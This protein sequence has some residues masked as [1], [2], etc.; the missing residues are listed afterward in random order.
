MRADLMAA[1]I[2]VLLASSAWAGV[3][4]EQPPITDT[5][6]GNY[7]R[8]LAQHL[9]TLECLTSDPNGSVLGHRGELK[10]ATFGS[11]DRICM[12]TSSGPNKGTSWTCV[13]TGDTCPGGSDTFVQ[14]NDGGSCGGDEGFTF[15]ESTNLVNINEATDGDSVLLLLQ[16]DQL[17]V[18]G[19]A[20]ETSQI[21]FGFGDDTDAARII[22]GKLGNFA[23]GPSSQNAFLSFNLDSAGVSTEIM[24][25]NGNTLASKGVSIGSVL[26]QNAAL[27]IEPFTGSS[28]FELWI[29]QSSGGTIDSFVVDGAE[30]ISGDVDSPSDSLF[31]VLSD[32]LSLLTIQGRTSDYPASLSLMDE[33]NVTGVTFL[34]A[35][36]STAPTAFYGMVVASTL[37]GVESE[38]PLMV[39]NAQ[40]QQQTFLSGGGVTNF[41]YVQ[42]LNPTLNGVVGGPTET[43][44]NAATVYIDGAPSGSNITFTNGPYALWVDDGAVRFD[45]TVTLGSSTVT[46]ITSTGDITSS[47]TGDIG[48]SIVTGANTA[49]N[50]TCTS[51]CVHG[52]DTAAGE[53]A[54]A[55]SDATADK[56]LCAGAS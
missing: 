27:Y 2:S 45:G 50:T 1:V 33:A 30:V 32:T 6:L 44:T 15:T 9:N 54:V 46:T 29:R 52:W 26:N 8:D 42:F 5:A 13:A 49:C 23:N 21:R 43:I 53:V 20:N 36:P 28:S 3:P 39:F 51:A 12:N 40:S 48:W 24:R 37:T 19:S 18:I 17:N 55:C 16:N 35:N 7:L 22:A 41:R 25:L 10:C 47:D 56:C 14:Y 4:R 34:L 38:S 11:I 31:S